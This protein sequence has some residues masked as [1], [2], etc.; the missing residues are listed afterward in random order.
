MKKAELN[1]DDI[2]NTENPGA[3]LAAEPAQQTSPAEPAE[4]PEA[5]ESAEPAQTAAVT[6]EELE[7]LRSRA[8]KADER[9]DRLLRVT[10]DFDNCKK[11]TAREK[12]EAI[13]F[14]NEGLIE[15]LL[16]VLDNF[17]IAL[18]T[19]AKQTGDGTEAIQSF[20]TGMSMIY[21]QLKGVLADAG[22]EELNTVGQPFDPNWHEAVSQ[23]ETTDAPEGRILQQLRKGYK[24]R[25][26]LLRAATVVVA[27]SPS[28]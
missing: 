23:Q 5:A 16:P 27:K 3:P 21:Q 1:T 14:A 7:E 17:E 9:W 8:A 2:E 25:D 20:H 22:L 28:T 24:L 12:Q 4:S 6:P 10:A 11:R 13:R 18:A 26:R 19:A 15:K